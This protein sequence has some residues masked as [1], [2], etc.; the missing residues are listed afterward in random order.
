MHTN[1]GI[2]DRIIRVFISLVMIGAALFFY[3]SMGIFGLVFLI[4]VLLYLVIT[5]LIGW[6]PFYALVGIDTDL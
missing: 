6:D 3:E 2:I 4:P 5:G 1:I